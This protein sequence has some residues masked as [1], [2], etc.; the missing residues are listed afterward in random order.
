MKIQAI[1]SHKFLP[2]AIQFFMWLF[3]PCENIRI[4]FFNLF[5]KEN[6]QYL[7]YQ[8]TYNHWSVIIKGWE[9]EAVWPRVIKSRYKRNHHEIA[10]WNFKDPPKE[11]IAWLESIVGRPY[12]WGDLGFHI[13]K[14]I[15]GKWYGTNN[16]N[17]ETCIEIV[18]KVL[19]YPAGQNP[20]ETQL[21]LG[22]PDYYYHSDDT[23]TF[24]R[25]I[26]WIL[27]RSTYITLGL[28]ALI[29]LILTITGKIFKDLEVTNYF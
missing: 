22:K 11:K 6:K 7:K 8:K 20:F 29:T 25:M 28:M 14:V 19:G 15:T 5:H 26:Q 16:D 13:L 21:L 10:E 18:N 24:F 3:V 12:G 23:T 17:K 4:F 27:D 9:Y 2:L 1:R